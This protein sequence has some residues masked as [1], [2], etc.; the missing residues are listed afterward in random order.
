[1]GGWHG[2]RMVCPPSAPASGA[3]APWYPDNEE[4]IIFVRSAKNPI[5]QWFPFNIVIGGS[6]ANAMVQQAEA[7]WVSKVRK[8]G[9]GPGTNPAR[10]ESA[11]SDASLPPFPLRS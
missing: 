1:M 6:S 7:E 8:R 10:P 4:F 11:P 3:V 9:D 5:A 2:R